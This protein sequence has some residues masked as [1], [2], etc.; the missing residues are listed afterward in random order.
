MEGASCTNDRGTC[1]RT[2]KPKGMV[3]P[4][5]R[6]GSQETSVTSHGEPRRSTWGREGG[7]QRRTKLSMGLRRRDAYIPHEDTVSGRRVRTLDKLMKNNLGIEVARKDGPLASN[8]SRRCEH[9]TGQNNESRN[10][11][12]NSQGH[13]R[14]R[15]LA[16]ERWE[17][18]FSGL[19]CVE[20]PKY[21]VISTDKTDTCP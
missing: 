15:S 8:R 12:F 3:G 9:Q 20:S 10:H 14:R 19:G 1:K 2:T 18:N 21:L 13:G 5:E 11:F 16:G 17:R 4:E 6:E 7:R